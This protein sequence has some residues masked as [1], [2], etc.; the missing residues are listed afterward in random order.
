[1]TCRRTITGDGVRRRAW[2]A[3]LTLLAALAVL[4]HHDMSGAPA[5]SATAV[6]GTMPGA[7]RTAPHGGTAAAAGGSGRTATGKAAAGHT[8]A[9]HA[10][11]GHETGDHAMSG[12]GMSARG[13]PGY[14][15]PRHGAVRHG[16]AAQAVT[17][18]LEH[19]ADGACS[20]PG[21]QHC[22][23]GAV[24][25]PQLLAPPAL[26]PHAVPSAPA[27]GVLAGLGLPGHPHRAPPDLSVL[28]RLLI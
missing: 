13:T 10:M 17:S 27:R 18:G 24:G 6:M 20:G 25:S 23:S 16:V 15:M 21:M 19:D 28:S 2:A 9:D 14:A 3:V 7:A 1:M 22:T 8:M 11:P 5:M 4:V 12:H 26:A